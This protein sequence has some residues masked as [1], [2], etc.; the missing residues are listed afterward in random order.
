MPRSSSYISSVEIREPD[1]SKNPQITA[2]VGAF[3]VNT[4]QQSLLA[5]SPQKKLKKEFQNGDHER[6]NTNHKNLLDP[7]STDI[8]AS[9]VTN[10]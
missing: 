1:I 3:K 7:R 4:T 9:T 10:D 6:L 8:I 5:G 2:P